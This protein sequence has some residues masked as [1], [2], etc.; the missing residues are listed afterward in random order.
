MR[1]SSID[2]DIALNGRI[3]RPGKTC[4]LLPRASYWALRMAIAA[5]ES[6]TACSR[7]IF[8][9]RAG[10][11][12]AAVSNETSSHAMLR[13]SEVRHAV[14]MVS[15]SALDAVVSIPTSLVMNWGSSR[16]S[17]AAWCVRGLPTFFGLGSMR[18]SQPFQRAGFGL[19]GSI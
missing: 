17:M 7:F 9:R 18:S 16:Y 10:M 8:I 3:G 19:S 12:H 13:T 4:G 11:T 2:I 15:V 5:S 6:G 1:L 14:R